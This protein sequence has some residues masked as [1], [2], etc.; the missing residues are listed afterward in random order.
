MTKGADYF[1]TGI[2]VAPVTNWRYYDNIYTE[3]FMQKPQDN[4]AGY[5]DNSPI[6]HV[7]K[8]KGNYLLIHGSSDDNVHFQNTM[9]LTTALVAAN[10]QFEQQFYPNSNHGIYTGRNTTF[11]L[12][13]RMT[14]F[15]FKHLLGR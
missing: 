8:L 9:D 2:A 10:K 7:S 13:T 6:S 1:S 3:R 11:H 15:L 4:P 14:N 5:D 12:Y